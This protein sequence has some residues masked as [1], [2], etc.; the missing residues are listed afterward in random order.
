MEAKMNRCGTLPRMLALRLVIAVFV[1]S[2][3]PAGVASA[4]A[5]ERTPST[6]DQQCLACHGI[7]GMQKKLADGETLALHVPTALFEKSVHRSIGCRGCHSDINLATHP[8]AHKV[9]A[10]KRS[11]ALTMTRICRRCHADKFDQ[12]QSSIH[13]TLVRNGDPRAPVC[14]NCH[15]PHA[16][17]K[18]AAA[19]IDQVPCK[20]CHT[21][22]YT[23]YLGSVHG[24]VRR[25]S[26]ESYA[27]ICFDCHSAHDV[28]PPWLGEGP[29]KACFGCHSGVLQ[30]HEQWLPNAAL[31]FKAVSCPACHVPGAQRKVDLML[32]DSR[33]IPRDT[34]QIGV[35]LFEAS[36]RSDGK[37]ISASTLWKLLQ[38]FN[39][40]GLIGKTVLRG[41]LEVRTGAE[42]HRLADASK[43]LSNCQVC[44][45]AGSKA[46]RSVTISL[47]GPDGRRVAFGAK[48]NVLR[49]PISLES[50]SGFYAIGGTRI[51]LLD[52]LFLIALVGGLAVPIG[53]LT[54]GWV[55]KRYFPPRPPTPGNR[56]DSDGPG[57]G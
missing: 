12:W 13:A 10:S 18:G 7:A 4:F 23:A 46:F 44:H 52:V 55:F 38:T 53:H 39:R 30:A 8:P 57:A 16:V 19:Q 43:A 42:A 21:A 40:V 3:L 32:I 27:P 14:I 51:E 11:F 26:H 29:E 15:N 28:K 20:K 48:A 17:I 9:I 31:H 36:A 54:M 24:Q 33:A 6:A 25:S 41:R 5:A 2:L 35:P 45:S 49:S 22:I 1:V 50:V 56:P 34:R 47:V 37:G